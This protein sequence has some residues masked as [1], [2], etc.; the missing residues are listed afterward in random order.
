MKSNKSLIGIAV[1]IVINFGLATIINV[2]DDYP[3]IQEAINAAS[4]GDTIQ[5]AAGTYAEQVA[6][7]GTNRKSLT[8]IGAGPTTVICPTSIPQLFPRYNS[9]TPN[10]AAIFVADSVAGAGPVVIKNLKIDASGITTMPSGA[11]AFHGIHFR[12]TGGLIDNVIVEGFVSTIYPSVA[13]YF[14]D[15]WE[16]PS[17]VEVSYS[18]FK[19]FT[20][21]GLACNGSYATVNF[22]HDS[23]F[24]IAG[25]VPNQSPNGIQIGFGAS[26]SITNNYI[27]DLVSSHPDWI[28]CGILV[29][30]AGDEV[31]STGNTLVQN[32][33]HIVYDNSEGEITGNI[34]IEPVVAGY[35]WTGGIGIQVYPLDKKSHK[36]FSAEPYDYDGKYG[37]NAKTTFT[38]TI[39]NNNLTGDDGETSEGIYVWQESP[40]S[41]N[42]TIGNNNKI[43]DWTYG[44]S[45][46]GAAV[47]VTGH[48]NN[49]MSNRF[50]YY[51][52]ED[53][54][55]PPQANMENNWWGH[56]SGPYHATLNLTGQ[57]DTIVGDV[58]F[59]PWLLTEYGPKTI[60]ATA[61]GPGT[62]TPSGTVVVNYGEDKTFEIT[63][64]TGCG[65]DSVL[66]DG[67]NVG[68]PL[69]Y[70]F[71]NVIT[72]HT[73]TA[74]FSSAPGYSSLPQVPQA[75]DVKPGKHVKDGGALVAAGNVL[76]AFHGNKSW[77]FYKYY[78]NRDSWAIMESIPY[79]Y[80]YKITTGVDS[81]NFNRKKVSKGAALCYDGSRYIYATKGNG[82]YEFWKYDTQNDTWYLVSYVPTA[83]ALKGG[84]SLAYLDGYVYLLAGGQDWPVKQDSMFFRYNI[85]SGAWEKLDNPPDENPQKPKKWKDGSA[86]V[87]YGD[88]IYAM[89]GGDK[90]NW[91]HIYTP[92]QGWLAIPET[93]T[94]FDSIWKGNNWKRN[95]KI[96]VK[97]GG[98]ITAGD[99]YLYAIKGGGIP[100]LY[101]YTP[102][103][104][105][106]WVQLDTI[107]PTLDKKRTPKT[108]AAMAYIYPFIYLMKGN[109]TDE[110]WKYNVTTGVVVEK[111]S[112]ATITTAALSYPGPK[113]LDLLDVTPNP[114]TKLA[115]VRYNVPQTGR[116]SLK[117]YDASGRVVSTLYEG[118]LEA[119]TYTMTVDATRLAR[120]VYFL[121]CEQGTEKAEVKL[122]VR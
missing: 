3:T 35:G 67:T 42:L 71:Q 117:L 52:W 85:A 77:Q 1:L 61:Y 27:E 65:L 40:H 26:G 109:N 96:Y 68:T 81:N 57:G 37:L 54:G 102:G 80:K 104:P 7:T 89:K 110:F 99:D 111:I 107:P 20:K 91:F 66:V 45:I 112:S 48:Y 43:K 75:G 51:V 76:Y 90:P 73:I 97:D 23:V 25:T 95:Q 49:I 101:R 55:N 9:L 106:S 50:G 84:T 69:S 2:P 108:G 36:R 114:L 94:T 38:Y 33:Y 4:N 63:P 34:M 56:S 87:A 116:V 100:L 8:F 72:D 47:N 119:G 88:K 74:Y 10:T 41:V 79:G 24:G 62:I 6:L 16:E 93:L 70:T 30:F 31:H 82:T 39:A 32:E 86:I 46:Y 105:Y 98:A 11:N 5:I 115:T 14:S 44:I 18:V 121:K 21:G 53:Y 60:I 58:D 12:E 120:G 28:G 78:P 59:E 13:F 19:D 15:V 29:Y 122:L 64:N 17:A 92:G 83:K 113:Q 22:H 118:T 103:V